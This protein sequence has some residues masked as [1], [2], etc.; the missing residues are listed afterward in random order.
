MRPLSLLPA[1]RR[2]SLV[3]QC[4]RTPTVEPVESRVLL[5]ADPAV[6]R[7]DPSFGTGG[8]TTVDFARRMES[9]DDV[10]LQPDAKILIG[11]WADTPGPGD[12]NTRYGALARLNAD[13]TVDTTFG[14]GDGTVVVER[15][16]QI[17]ELA[18]L[19]DGRIIAGGAAHGGNRPGSMGGGTNFALCRFGPDGTLDTTFGN[20][21]LAAADFSDLPG[22][23]YGSQD[24]VTDLAID[25]AGRIVAA[26]Y[27]RFLRPGA[28][29]VGGMAV[30]RFTPGG[31]LDEEFGTGGRT[32]I[33]FTPAEVQL[34]DPDAVAMDLAADGDI[35]LGAYVYDDTAGN[36]YVAAHKT[37]LARLNPDGTGDSSFGRKG[38]LLRDDL[39]IFG[40]L[41]ATPDNGLVISGSPRPPADGLPPPIPGVVLVKYGANGSLDESFGQTGVAHGPP[42]SDTGVL[43]KLWRGADGSIVVTAGFTPYLAVFSG[44]GGFLRDARGNPTDHYEARMLWLGGAGEV[45]AVGNSPPQ[46]V[47]P[48]PS[49]PPDPAHPPSLYHWEDTDLVVTRLVAREGGDREH[50]PSPAPPPQGPPPTPPE[51][52]TPPAP[53]SLR[54]DA[55]PAWI[56]RGRRRAQPGR[57]YTFR[58]RYE[59]VAAADV[60][61]YGVAAKDADTGAP[62]TAI[63][64]R[65][66]TGRR[67]VVVTYRLAP[68]ALAEGRTYD[69]W[70]TAPAATLAGGGNAPAPA[71]MPAG[72]F[73]T[74]ARRKARPD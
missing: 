62:V 31:S 54:N 29:G 21:G 69:V 25:R 64:V 22:D 73:R 49:Q 45:I 57:A 11:G 27:T 6:L 61:S 34:P 17:A 55:P 36:D 67:A 12:G 43:S 13:G 7:A 28:G 38:K 16:G 63:A 19:D 32:I 70:V 71:T 72:T 47:P 35:L 60:A 23:P 26:G 30:A 58:L 14:G 68:Q 18:L 40:D 3:N 1:F 42:A 52:T 9:G 44:D 4:R 5:A 53:P 15:M 41:L 65:A 10:I 20:G 59:G 66:R 74:R 46:F 24:Y 33:D 37:A 8:H 51:E 39:G 50:E 56:F 48:D 2:P